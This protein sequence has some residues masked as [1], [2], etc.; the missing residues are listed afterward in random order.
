MNDYQKLI[1]KKIQEEKNALMVLKLSD[2]D[3]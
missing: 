3:L 2:A 1:A